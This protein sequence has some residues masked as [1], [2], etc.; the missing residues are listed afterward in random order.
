MDKKQYRKILTEQKE[1]ITYIMMNAPETLNAFDEIMLDEMLE[2]IDL[3][4]NDPSCRV[5]VIKGHGK[6]FSA[7]GDIMGMKHHLETDISEFFRP[8]LL[9][10]NQLALAIRAL[11]KPVI[12]SVHGAAAGAGF[13]LAL[14]CDFIV[15]SK[16]AKFV[17][18]FVNLGLIPDMGGTYFLSRALPP[19]KT[20]ELTMLGEVISA[21]SLEALSI[22]NRLADDEDLEQETLTFA[23]KLAAKPKESL[24]T[25]KSMIN[26]ISYPELTGLLEAEFDYQMYLAKQPDFAEGIAS[27]IEKRPPKFS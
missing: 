5:V 13:N 1:S 20:M 4:K 23:K 26:K 6:G 16:K 21:E 2:V 9:R 8:V 27:F 24:S 10:V 12:A 22:I 14:C 17:Q 15:A 19:S 25:S 3:C 11:P 7:G 18:A